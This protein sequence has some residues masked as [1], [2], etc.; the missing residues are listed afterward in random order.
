MEFWPELVQRKQK[1]AIFVTSVL[2]VNHTTS[3]ASLLQ[4]ECHQKAG[5]NCLEILQLA[6][7]F[8]NHYI[9]ACQ[10]SLLMS[11][12]VCFRVSTYIFGSLLGFSVFC[13]FAVSE[14]ALWSVATFRG[15][16]YLRSVQLVD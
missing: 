8:G 11:V 9:F 2:Y 15:D 13:W 12:L 1:N 14:L 3:P 5:R 6:C 4:G 7:N 10:L 16:S